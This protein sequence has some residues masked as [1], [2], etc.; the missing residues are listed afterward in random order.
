MK[1]NNGKTVSK[2]EWLTQALEVLSVEGVQGV[3]IERL[4][5]DLRYLK[6]KS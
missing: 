4:A 5:R 1:A 3:R 6:V 2:G